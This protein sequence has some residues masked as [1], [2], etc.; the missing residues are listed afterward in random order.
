MRNIFFRGKRILD[1]EWVYGY[2]DWSSEKGYEIDG[3]PVDEETVGQDTGAA[4]INGKAIFE[5]D[6]VRLGTRADFRVIHDDDTCSF[7]L[8]FIGVRGSMPLMKPHVTVLAEVIGNIWDNPEL[9]KE[10]TT[11]ERLQRF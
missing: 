3:Y 4:D 2:L 8:G 1:G 9:L 5:G 10:E 11:N 7:K 6:I